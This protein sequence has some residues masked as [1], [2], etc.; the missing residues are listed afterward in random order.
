MYFKVT[1]NNLSSLYSDHFPKHSVQYKVGEFVSPNYGQLFCYHLRHFSEDRFPEYASID[2][3]Y[4]KLWICECVNPI[5]TEIYPIRLDLVDS[6]IEKV[7]ITERRIDCDIQVSWPRNVILADQ[8]KLVREITLEEVK[9]LYLET[10]KT[11]PTQKS[12]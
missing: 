4:R 5:T 11:F 1:N 2:E 7:L 10:Y 8:V 6:Y 9:Q 12:L 3:Q